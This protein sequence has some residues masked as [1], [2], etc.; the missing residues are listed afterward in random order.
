MKTSYAYK[1]ICLVFL[2]AILILSLSGCSDSN[3]SIIGGDQPIV[4]Q[5]FTTRQRTVVLDSVPSDSNTIFPY[6]IQKYKEN[7]YGTWSYGGGNDYGKQTEIMPAG[8][9]GASV[10][11]T[12]RLLNFFTIT[13]IHI[14]DKE[15]PAQSIYA[16]YKGGNSS[17]Y[18]PVMLYTTHVLD[19]AVRTI[20][21]LHRQNSFDFGI[22]L[23]DV[24]NSSQY[25]EVRWYI[26]V[27]DGR[28]ITPSSGNHAGAD[29]IDYQKPYQAAGL[30]RTIPWYQTLGNHDHFWCGA[31]PV[32]DYLRQYYTGEN[33]LLLGDLFTQGID[34]RTDYMGAIDGRTPYGEIIGVGP[35][36]DFSTPPKVLAADPDRRPL[37]RQEWMG[38][39]F[40]T[41]SNPVGHGFNQTN[42]DSDFTCYS[43]E[44]K[45]D[46]PI[47]V[48]VL[49][50]TQRDEDYDLHGNGYIDKTRYDWLVDELDK[51]Q[52][53]GKLM[54]ISAHVPVSLMDSAGSYKSSTDMLFTLSAYSNLILWVTGH[55][56]VNTVRAHPSSD[57][58][59]QGAEYGF[60]EIET[61]SLRDFPQQFHT[62]DILRNS[63]N[64]ISIIKTAVDPSVT[65]GSPAA[66]SRSYAVAAQQLFNNPIPHLPTGVYNAEFVKQLSPEMEAKI[67]NYGTPI[68]K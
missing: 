16:G 40:K 10:T 65:E 52:A 34:A 20:N 54:I 11:N 59:Y 55:V 51:G 4:S 13:D 29:T 32:I 31:Y 45:S 21:A 30:D 38:E 7:G 17:A 66:I 35:V 26:D 64:T 68:I 61:S 2:M 47:K 1:K 8:Y 43:F 42:V 41:S 49:D 33:I 36:G 9:N 12:A 37:S 58:A 18:S 6:E 24:C 46:I 27:L 25:N 56:H 14:V 48:I 60:W 19:A 63:D 3:Q 67:Q 23:G 53:E 50:N 44:P 62:F 39:F 28:F 57:P 5:V 22:S 15:S